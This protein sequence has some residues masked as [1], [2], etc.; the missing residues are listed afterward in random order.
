MKPAV[1]I[2]IVALALMVGGYFYFKNKN[3][4]ADK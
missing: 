2:G 3:T 1:I 4:P